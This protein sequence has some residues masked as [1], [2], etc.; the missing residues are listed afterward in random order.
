MPTPDID[1]Q[2]FTTFDGEQL[3]LANQEG[4]SLFAI[5]WGNYGSPPVDFLTRR[6]YKQDG[7][8]VVDYSLG[9][10]SILITFYQ[11][12]A[13]TRQQYWQYRAAL[14]D[15][16]RP[17][18]GGALTLLVREAGGT[19]RA[20]KVYAAPGFVFAPSAPDESGF[21]IQEPITFIAYDPIWFDPTQASCSGSGVAAN[22]LIFPETFPI[23]FSP[24]GTTYTCNITYVGNWVSYPTIVLTGPYTSA[25]VLN[26]TTG[27]SFGLVLPIGPGQ[28]RTI[29]TTPGALS[30]VDQSG[31]DQWGDLSPTSDLVNFNIR[32]SP[33]VTGGI[34][35][36]L[37]TLTGGLLGTSSAVVRYYSRYLGI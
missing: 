4:D 20:L 15:F 33:M 23:T 10:R 11:V 3:I 22:H 31:V 2:S 9:D 36:L 32:P 30:I 8:T 34:N 14:I 16:F 12:T 1:V 17:N 6:G 7:S 19:K 29:V 37:I 21:V 27:F 35:Q 13:C 28:T 24:D 18:R 5:S 26:V 25:T